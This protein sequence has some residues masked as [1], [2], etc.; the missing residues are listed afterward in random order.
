LAQKRFQGGDVWGA[1]VEMVEAYKRVSVSVRTE[2]LAR[3]EAAVP[4]NRTA[5]CEDFGLLDW[6]QVQIME[7]EGLLDFGV[8]TATHKILTQ[9]VPADMGREILGARKTL[10]HHLS[11]SVAAFCYPN[12]RPGIDFYDEHKETLRQNGYRCAFTTHRALFKPGV[13]DA[14]SI[15]RIPA[16]HDATSYPEIFRWNCA[17]LPG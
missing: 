13:D 17:G 6:S 5:F 16:G 12:G 7:R 1:Y 8:H 4:L 15:G 11:R 10:E 9:M 14:F 3:L 2:R